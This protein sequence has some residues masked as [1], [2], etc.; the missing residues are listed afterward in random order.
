MASCPVLWCFILF[1]MYVCIKN[2]NQVWCSL[3]KQIV[4]ENYENIYNI[5]YDVKYHQEIV[6]IKEDL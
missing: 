4:M 3:H 1:S 5:G 2:V 6:N